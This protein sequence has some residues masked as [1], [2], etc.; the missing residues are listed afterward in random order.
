MDSSN[1]YFKRYQEDINSVWTRKLV[2]EFYLQ[3]NK[4][5]RK[6]HKEL[7]LPNFAFSLDHTKWGTWSASDRKLTLTY[8]LLK[9]FEWDAVVHTLKHEMAHQIVSEIWGD[10]SD[11]GNSHGELFKKACE[12]LEVDSATH[13]STAEK[14]DYRIPEKD[15]V[16]SKIYKLFCLG[17]SNHKAEAESA[18]AK[19]HELM[20]KHNIS[21]RDL[22]K[23]KR[24]FVFRPVGEIY[25]NVPQYVKVLSRI[26]SQYYFIKYIFIPISSCRA[27]YFCREKYVEFYGEPENVDIAEYIY[28]FLLYE[29]ERQWNEF[30]QSDKYKNRFADNY[31]DSCFYGGRR[32]GAYSKIAF[33]TGL[34]NG[35]ADTLE[36]RDNEI[37]DQIIEGNTLPICLDDPLLEEKYK[38]HYHPRTWNSSSCNSGGGYSEGH[39][40]GQGIK[41]RNG[42][43]SGIGNGRVL[44]GA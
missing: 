19:A 39:S 3:N 6:L 12:V 25:Q 10:I 14:N 42:V 29:G 15:R 17:E 37:K 44:L 41:I 21:L 5:E 38:S 1:E 26:V 24:Q 43:A 30:R 13:H 9:N 27:N 16:I 31:Y 18:V 11:N 2:G 20:I 33:L 32:K 7:N 8:H 28:H 34:Y 23:E 40:R 4:I 36:K 35:Y 22:P